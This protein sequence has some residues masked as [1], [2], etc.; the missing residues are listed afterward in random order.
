MKALSRDVNEVEVKYAVQM[1]SP[2]T[3]MEDGEEKRAHALTGGYDT[4]EEAKQALTNMKKAQPSDAFWIWS[5]VKI[6]TVH[7][8]TYEEV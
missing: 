3:Y 7:T 1:A 2:T 8:V 5:V 4:P 6:T